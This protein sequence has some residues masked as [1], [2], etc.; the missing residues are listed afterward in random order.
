[1]QIKRFFKFFGIGITILVGSF[2]VAGQIA[3]YTV[4]EIEPPGKMYSI[5]GAN[6]HLHC[7]APE[8]N[9][10]EKPTVV[11]IPGAG[12][13][14]YVYHP[15]QQRLAETVHT[16]SYDRPG[17]GWSE[18]NEKR[19]GHA[20]NMSDDLHQLLQAANIDDPV[21][22]AGHSLGGTV[23]LIYSADH[24]EQVAGIAFIDSSHH[25]QYN[26]FGNE[27]SN[28][29]Y[30]EMNML[31]DNFWLAE[32][33]NNLGIS[34]LLMPI[35]LDSTEST[36]DENLIE[37][38]L[39]FNTWAPPF[40]AIKSETR[41]LKLSLEQGKEAFHDREDLPIIAMSASDVDLTYLLPKS[42]VS[43]KEMRDAFKSFHKDLADLSSNGIH[44][45]VEG[46]DHMNIVQRE[47]TAEHILSLIH[48]VGEK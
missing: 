24:E 29:V 30:D 45:I 6:M 40:D 28:A 21:I 12:T 26:H 9:N 41:N 27:F 22:L 32:I 44:V 2:L 43:E 13:A 48:L 38:T 23:S 15:L 16:C 35:L 3:H 19:D 39:S 8:N 1:M 31:M 18:P 33:L 14:S 36:I 10:D 11:I 34:N 5:N 42:N 20:K 17:L 7:I 47:K 46:T 4:P 37:M 25:N